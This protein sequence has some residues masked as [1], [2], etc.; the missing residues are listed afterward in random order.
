V[1]GSTPEAAAEFALTTGPASRLLEAGAVDRE[2][3]A[4]AVRDALAP[5]AREGRVALASASWC[6]TARNPG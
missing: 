3:A 1:L 4:R 5:H 2:R 6:V